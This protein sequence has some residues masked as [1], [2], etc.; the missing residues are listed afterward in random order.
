MGFTMS[1]P[2][3]DMANLGSLP[4]AFLASMLLASDDLKSHERG[5]RL[6]LFKMYSPSVAAT[7]WVQ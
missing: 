2:H 3:H 6:D 1:V 5:T 7:S 4:V